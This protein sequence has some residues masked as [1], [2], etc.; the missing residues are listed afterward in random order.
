MDIPLAC[1]EQLLP[2]ADLIDKYA[3]AVSLG[4][5]GIELRGRGSW[6]SPGGCRSCA[7]PAPPGW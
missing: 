7:G 4:Y 3:L 1:Q 5:R 2:G 6:R